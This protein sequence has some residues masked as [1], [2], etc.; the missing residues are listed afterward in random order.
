M[1]EENIK[2]KRILSLLEIIEDIKEDAKYKEKEVW[3]KEY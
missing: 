2:S 3:L 1:I